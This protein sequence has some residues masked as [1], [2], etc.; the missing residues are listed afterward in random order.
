MLAVIQSESEWKEDL[1]KGAVNMNPGNINGAPKGVLPMP[2]I[3]RAKIAEVITS[4]FMGASLLLL[5]LRCIPCCGFFFLSFLLNSLFHCL[6]K[7]G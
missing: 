5:F 7:V 4:R 2:T 3:T 1:K 6:I